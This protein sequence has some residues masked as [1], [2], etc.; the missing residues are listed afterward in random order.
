MVVTD[1]GVCREVAQGEDGAD[2]YDN[3]RD[4]RT[5]ME[6]VEER[7]VDR[8]SYGLAGRG[9]ERLAHAV[10][11]D[12][13]ATIKHARLVFISALRLFIV[14]GKLSDPLSDELGGFLI[15]PGGVAHLLARRVQDVEGA[16]LEGFS[17]ADC[18]EI[19]GDEIER[20]VTWGGA[21]GVGALAGRPVRLRFAL[22]DAD[23]CS[24]QFRG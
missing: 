18:D 13:T 20:V 5:G 9:T 4:P 10:G 15:G 19:F 16:P 14:F 21:A 12:R 8:G 6:A 7:F 1:R 3:G 2:E 23:L 17:L 22:R 11:D 24:I